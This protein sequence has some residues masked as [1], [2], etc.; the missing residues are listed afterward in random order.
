MRAVDGDVECA[1]HIHIRA[2][3]VVGN[4]RKPSASLGAILTVRHIQSLK[5][6]CCP[7]GPDSTSASQMN[8]MWLVR[9]R[10]DPTAAW[11]G[12][13]NVPSHVNLAEISLRASPCREILRGSVGLGQAIRYAFWWV[14][15]SGGATFPTYQPEECSRTE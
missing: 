2:V 1:A 13:R 15:E 8:G 3:R 14:K 5:E 10:S 7:A 4:P 12:P 11:G 6:R 9:R